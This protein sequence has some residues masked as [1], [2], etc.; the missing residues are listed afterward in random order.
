MT[1]LEILLITIIWIYIGMWINKKRGYYKDMPYFI[2]NRHDRHI[3]LF[4]NI[5]LSPFVML[6]ITL[7]AVYRHIIMEDWK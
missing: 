7:K 1:F 5:F 4:L 2:E 3:A 6:W